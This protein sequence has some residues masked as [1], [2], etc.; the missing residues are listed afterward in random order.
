[1]PK[2]G[3]FRVAKEVKVVA[4]SA[5]NIGEIITKIAQQVFPEL[6][7]LEFIAILRKLADRKRRS[8]ILRE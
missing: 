8:H 3:L 4:N 2:T 7:D 6:S 5:M 1:M